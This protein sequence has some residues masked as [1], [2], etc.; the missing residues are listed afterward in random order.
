MDEAD[1]FESQS[2]LD[3]P[4]KRPMMK[5]VNVVFTRARTRSVNELYIHA[6]S[7]ESLLEDQ[8]FKYASD[9]YDV[10]LYYSPEKCAI[11]WFH[12]SDP[13]LQ[14]IYGYVNEC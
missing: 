9:F 10:T 6:E 8:L 1:Y 14:Y 5:S 12:D 11:M 4:E 13:S 2:H 3:E 7:I